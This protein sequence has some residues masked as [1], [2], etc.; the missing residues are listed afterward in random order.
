M[1]T[2][3][4]MRKLLVLLHEY[5]AEP[6]PTDSDAAAE[7]DL[8]YFD[9]ILGV[10]GHHV[11]GDPVIAGQQYR[12]RWEID[13]HA[14]SHLDA[15][16]QAR[17]AQAHAD[18]TATVFD[19]V[20]HT[21]IGAE[22]EWSQAQTVDLLA[23]RSDDEVLDEIAAVLRSEAVPTTAQIAQLVQLTGRE[24]GMADTAPPSDAT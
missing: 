5:L 1:A 23:H 3:P 9:R 2:S 14:R 22:V 8:D 7:R 13:V 10:L 11:A 24:V 18:S 15:A 4:T 6:Q 12:V 17:H 20:L 21:D 19:V 16:R